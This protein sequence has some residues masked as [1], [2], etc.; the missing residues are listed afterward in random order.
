MR[1]RDPD[2]TRARI[3]AA[4]RQRIGREGF[5]A[6]SIRDILVDTGVTKGALY[7]H[8]PSK[9]ALGYAVVDEHMRGVIVELGARFEHADDPLTTMQGIVREKIIGA[10]EDSLLQGCPVVR[11]ADEMCA[12]DDGFK[13]RMNELFG[14]L[15][16]VLAAALRRGQRTGTVRASISPEGTALCFACMRNG[17]LGLAARSQDRELVTMAAESW[18]HMLDGLRP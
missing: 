16:D 17:I 14:E 9:T 15:R 11:L 10:A 13:D 2:T 5:R 3:L 8:F 18:I 6:A 12:H 4:A 1:V 7:H